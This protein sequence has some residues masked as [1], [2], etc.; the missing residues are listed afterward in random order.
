[1]KLY[2]ISKEMTQAIEK[3][4]QAVSDEELLEVEQELAAVQLAFDQKAL[5]VGY[6]LLNL[7]ADIAAIE[8]EE[9]RLGNLRKAVERKVA[10]LKQYLFMNMQA[11]KCERVESSTMKI[12]IMKNP[13]FVNILN[14][15]SVPET[16]KRTVTQTFIDKQKILDEWKKNKIGVEGTEVVQRERLSIR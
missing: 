4:N 13:P 16:Y 11:S 12:A 3:Y 15:E 1:M 9:V 5:A 14:E 2:E 10:W 7:N 6:H 8:T